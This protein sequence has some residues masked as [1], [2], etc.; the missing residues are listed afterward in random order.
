MPVNGKNWFS[1]F[2]FRPSGIFLIALI[3]SFTGVIFSPALQS[4]GVI[5]MLIALVWEWVERK[6]SL[7]AM[8]NPVTR[9]QLFIP[10]ILFGLLLT[11]FL[12]GNPPQVVFDAVFS[13]MA[14]VVIPLTIAVFHH[15]V[16]EYVVETIILGFGILLAGVGVLTVFR[17][18]GN[19]TDYDALLVQSKHIP[20]A[21]G[22]NHIYFSLASAL[23]LSFILFSLKEY[24]YLSSRKRW[25]IAMITGVILL[26][27]MH[28]LST[29]TGLVVLYSG[30]GMALILSAFKG[31]IRKKTM[32][33]ALVVMLTLPVMAFLSFSSFRSKLQNSWEDLQAMSQ[34]GEEINHKSM[35]MRMESYRV[36]AMLFS[37]YWAI[38]TGK[39]NV[40]TEMQ[41][42]YVRAHSL[43]SPENR[44]EPHNQFLHFGIAFGVSGFLL[45]LFFWILPIFDFRNIHPVF[46]AVTVILF[47]T[48]M[49]EPLLE[50]QSGMFLFFFFYFWF[51]ERH[52]ETS[53]N[54]P[55]HLQQL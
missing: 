2:S 28:I 5:F 14:F 40:K 24:Q 11:D 25:R 10:I 1:Y 6:R 55:L 17:Y 44:I 22:M 29:R 20:I 46:F 3:F 48:S 19:K 26:G 27:C 9:M 30:M 41:D 45:F 53:A 13:R 33:I 18:F 4:T 12:R 52:H 42:A 38:G 36:G 54:Y 50:R 49:L 39:T 16:R 47:I 34:G 35:G 15:Q 43:L 51:M 21:G 37:E 31:W 8:T 23:V 7:I 32:I